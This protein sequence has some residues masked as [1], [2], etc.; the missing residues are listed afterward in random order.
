MKIKKIE[1]RCYKEGVNARNETPEKQSII[2]L[3]LKEWLEAIQA[4]WIA[5]WNMI[6]SY[7]TKKREELL[8]RLP[9]IS[10]G[11]PY[12]IHKEEY[13]YGKIYFSILLLIS[14]AEFW[15]VLW[16]LRA[17][18][19]G[20]EIYLISFVIMS[21]GMLSIHFFL[22][23]L[24][25]N[26]P[27]LYNK[28]KLTI[29]VISLVA[30]LIAGL[31]LAKVRGDLMV[32]ERA[33]QEEGEVINRVDSF[34]DRT[35]VAVTVSMALIA[36]CLSLIGGVVMHEALPRLII[37]G[38]VLRTQKKAAEYAWKIINAGNQLESGKQIVKLGMVEF[39]R[40]LYSYSSRKSWLT[41]LCI[42]FLFLSPFLSSNL[43]ANERKNLCILVDQSRSTLCETLRE[44]QFQ[45]N[46]EAVPEIIKQAPP[47]SSIKIIGIT[48][49]FGNTSVLLERLLPE[50]P[51]TFREKLHKARRSLIEEL[52]HLDI[53]PEYSET[54][55]FGAIFYAAMSL[56]GDSGEKSLIILSDMRNSVLVNI[57]NIPVIGGTEVQRTESE[58]LIPDLAGVKV[59]ALGVSPCGKDLKYWK[60]LEKFWMKYFE[61]TGAQLLYFS[62]EREWKSDIKKEKGNERR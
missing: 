52:S 55:I 50:K 53:S 38:N 60:S 26:N 19:L 34:Y 59:Y 18:G 58:G 16:T 47:G 37:S 7:L 32:T 51:G 14:F 15:I 2:Q 29:T 13:K 11:I 9:E 1:S 5:T 25:E 46:L 20:L 12:E 35:S 21:T 62:M 10:R 24:K 6:G 36:L 27:K 28:T 61:K 42:L 43:F 45:K 22:N 3:N 39:K 49:S 44:S 4:K 48:D 57:E 30:I 41:P 31:A 17:Y 33:I 40:G 54:D 56:K 23:K 8:E